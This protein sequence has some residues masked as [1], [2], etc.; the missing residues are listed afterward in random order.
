MIK[1]ENIRKSF[2]GKDFFKDISFILNR[3]EKIGLV[4]KNGSGKSI[5]LKII[6]R[7]TEIDGGQVLTDKNEIIGYLPQILEVD[8][9][10]TIRAF[11]LEDKKI[12]DWQIKKFL[13]K[14]GISNI[15]LGRKLKG[16]SSGEL[17]KIALSRLLVKEPTILLLDEPTNNLDIKGMLYLQKFLFSFKGG[18]LLVS[19]DRWIL[20]KISTKIVVIQSTE[21]GNIS[22]IYPGNFSNYQRIRQKEIEKEGILYKL[23][24]KRIKRIEKNVK[25]RKEKAEILDRKAK[26]GL[27]QDGRYL[28]SKGGK[29]AKGAKAIKKRAE[30]FLESE[31]KINKIYKE[32]KFEFS[33]EGFLEKS[34][35]AAKIEDVSFSLRSRKEILKDINFEIFGKDRI[36]LLGPNGVGKTSFVKILF[37][38]ISPTKGKIKFNPNVKI[39][40]LPQEIIFKDYQK[41]V[42]EEFEK[43]I[44]ISENEARRILGRFLFSGEEQKKQ[45][46]DLSIGEGRKLYLAKIVASRANFLL[47][48]EPTNHLDI[49]S[50][51][52]IE[53]ALFQF[54][55][56][57]F[58]VSHDRYFL[59]NIG[60][61][62]FYYL[63]QGYF[64]EFYYLKDLEKIMS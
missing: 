10:R 5:L 23:Q 57:I 64:K 26:A 50:V 53:K 9:E 54:K 38:E 11:F 32:K 60:I 63:K 8:L 1:I 62:R 6:I 61:E 19:H 17:T 51:E 39:G 46:Q 37:G 27:T 29:M 56:A 58:I 41:T 3:G 28:L 31:G 15:D 33:F 55:G 34:Q 43:D 36:S 44:K 4:G 59:E 30:R 45:L 12:E 22:K 24:Q 35:R 48:D 18:I 25:E 47:L 49:L 52:A 14:L 16:L 20:D 42:F 7:E 21:E 40:Y 13:A 2:Q